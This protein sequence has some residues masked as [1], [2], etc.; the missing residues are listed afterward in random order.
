MSD[1]SPA[2]HRHTEFKFC[3]ITR[4]VD[5]SMAADLGASYVGV[6]FAESP[7]QVDETRARAIFDATSSG[8]G[9]VA[10]FGR[11]PNQA[12]ES[13][14]KAAG[15]SVLQLHG[16]PA[17]AEIRDL[18][19]RFDGE[20][21]AVIGI[22]PTEGVVPTEAFDLAAF[23]DAILIDASVGGRLGGTGQTLEWARLA[24][25]IDRLAER[26]RVILAG[27]LNPENV[28]VA[29]ETLHPSV[30]DVSSGIEASQGIKDPRRMKAFAEAV[31]S[32]SIVGRRST[33]SPASETE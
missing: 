2:N 8:I 9:H 18:R 29:I 22:E 31:R 25:S 27:G 10:V 23:A 7:R 3:G 12:I 5:A 26:A 16:G 28:G 17:P 20:I 19:R 13:K 15:A 32:A 30:V 14:A 24:D 6:I 21:W 33:P 1:K 11:E 4:P